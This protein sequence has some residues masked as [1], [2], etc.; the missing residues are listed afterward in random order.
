MQIVT[1]S[2]AAALIAAGLVL[3]QLSDNAIH[4]YQLYMVGVCELGPR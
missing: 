1:R 4:Q 2:T 3:I